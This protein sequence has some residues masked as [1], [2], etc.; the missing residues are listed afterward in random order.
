VEY[1]IVNGNI[2]AEVSIVPL[3]TRDCSL[4]KYV[5]DC[6]K[7]LEGYNDVKFQLTPMGTIIEGPIN[8]VLGAIRDMHEVPFQAGVQRVITTIKI[9]DRR[10]REST[11]GR[12]VESVLNKMQNKKGKA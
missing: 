3:G 1:K 10:D 12:K 9:D 4:S 2:I 5:A 6:L 7:V 11:M 8:S